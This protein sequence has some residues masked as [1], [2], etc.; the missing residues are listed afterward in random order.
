MLK[1]WKGVMYEKN[2]VVWCVTGQEHLIGA[3]KHKKGG[4]V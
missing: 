2:A 3:V 1:L 4:I